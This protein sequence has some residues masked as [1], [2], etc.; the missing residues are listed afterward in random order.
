LKKDEQRLVDLG[1]IIMTV[2]KF[3]AEPATYEYEKTL[4]YALTQVNQDVKEKVLMQL[5]ATEK[6]GK[7]KGSVS[8]ATK[9]EATGNSVWS[10]ITNFLG[11]FIPALKRK[12]QK[13]DT[14]LNKLKVLVAKIKK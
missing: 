12:G 2:V 5:K 9:T 8:F 7:T 4:D 3:Q 11:R 6:I 14:E 13:I 10:S 1:D